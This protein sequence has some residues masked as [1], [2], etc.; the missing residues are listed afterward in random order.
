MIKLC[1][2]P[3]PL[4]PGDLLKVIAPSGALR[5]MSAFEKGVEIWRKHGYQVQ[6]CDGITERWGYL[7]GQDQHRRYQLKEAWFNPDVKGI[8]CARGGF[9]SA[10]LLEDWTWGDGEMGRWGDGGMGRW[11]DGEMGRWGDG[12]MGRWGDGEMGRGGDG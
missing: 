9:G 1:Q 6:I 5:E 10:R 8:L 12:E 4:Q 3:A 11:G 2:I 7:A